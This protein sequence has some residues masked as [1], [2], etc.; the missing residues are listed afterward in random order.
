MTGEP[1]T[2]PVCEIGVRL[3]LKW[4]GI[5]LCTPCKCKFEKIEKMIEVGQVLSG[6]RLNSVL[7]YFGES[8]LEKIE[9]SETVHIDKIK[10]RRRKRV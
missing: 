10:K 8:E 4:R 3:I 5:Y 6:R 1:L 9:D 7:R 2:C